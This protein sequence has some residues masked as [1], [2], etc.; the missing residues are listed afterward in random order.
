M[1]KKRNNKKREVKEMKTNSRGFT[2]I[3]LLVVVAI[4]AILASMLLPALGKAM[5]KA[6][7]ATCLSNL[8]QIYAALSIYAQDYDGWYPYAPETVANSC[9]ASLSLLTGQIDKTTD[10]RDGAVYISGSE[11]FICPSSTDTKS[12]TGFLGDRRCSYSYASGLRDKTNPDTVL[13]ADKKW[14]YQIY[15]GSYWRNTSATGSLPGTP[16][17]TRWGQILIQYNQHK[18][19]GVNVLYAGGNAKWVSAAVFNV[20]SG[21]KTVGVLPMSEIPNMARGSSYNPGSLWEPLGF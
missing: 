15:P 4:I 19:Y 10:A 11:V 16:P 6:K 5:E 17:G 7:R 14:E 3:E 2:L 8:K 9:S 13:V 18:Y 1:R 21:Y 20:P 12:D